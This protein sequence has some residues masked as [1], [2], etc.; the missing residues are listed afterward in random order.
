MI[1]KH[2]TVLQKVLIA[3]EQKPG[4]NVLILFNKKNKRV[5]LLILLVEMDDI[6][7][8]SLKHI[9]M[10]LGLIFQENY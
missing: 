8:P 1:K 10:Q 7:S 6:S 9:I 3:H 2:G 5:P 4:K